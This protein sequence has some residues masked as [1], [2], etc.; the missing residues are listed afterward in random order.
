MMFFS[1]LQAIGQEPVMHGPYFTF[2]MASAA[3]GDLR[4]VLVIEFS[5]LIGWLAIWQPVDEGFQLV[6]ECAKV[7]QFRADRSMHQ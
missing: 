7:E 1:F 2:A 4:V 5:L 3:P 6:A